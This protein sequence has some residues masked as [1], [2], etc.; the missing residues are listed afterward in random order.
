MNK[1]WKS[2][3]E[4]IVEGLRGDKY[5]VKIPDVLTLV[6][7][8]ISLGVDMTSKN[9]SE[10]IS[11]EEVLRGML[12]KYMIEPKFFEELLEDQADTILIYKTII[13]EW[14]GNPDKVAE[15]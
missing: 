14:V 3:R 15:S 9:L 7:S 12:E 6:Q 2:K 11:K 4:V 13:S 8:W 1:E 10:E 5:L